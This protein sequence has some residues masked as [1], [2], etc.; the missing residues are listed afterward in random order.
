MYCCSTSPCPG[1]DG[2]TLLK[3]VRSKWPQ[4]AVV[5]LSMHP[6][7]QYATRALRGGALS[8]LTKDSA[9]EQLVE[10]VRAVA[11][12]RRYVSPGLA[13]L[14]AD[15]V[16]GD[17]QRTARSR[18][19]GHAGRV[20]DQRLDAPQRLPEGEHAGSS[21][22]LDCGSVT[23]LHAEGHHPAEVA[24]LSRGDVVA[25]MTLDPATR[26]R[27]VAM[28]P[29]EGES[30][31][32]SRRA[33]A[34]L[35]R[36]SVPGMAITAADGEIVLR[37]IASAPVAGACFVLTTPVARGAMITPDLVAAVPCDES[38]PGS[39]GFD[40]AA[41]GVVA[42]ADLAAGSPLGR[43]AAVPAPGIGKGAPLRL[44]SIAGPVRI[45]RQVTA[46]QPSRGRRVFVRDADGGIFAAPLQTGGTK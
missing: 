3:E 1:K 30:V 9:P 31:A 12:G 17:L 11:A 45:E 18:G 29:R 37:S 22:H 19:V 43:I 24:H 36:R 41:G 46:L 28:L 42:R 20:L 39:V 16:A 4:I 5:I 10:A 40:R 2:L 14:L 35:V 33:L 34:L 23:G 21:A 13:Q 6:E 7:R 15:Q 26:T 25:G 38:R 44:V 32:I 27:V 8:Y